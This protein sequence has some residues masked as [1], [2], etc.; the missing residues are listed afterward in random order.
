MKLK[1]IIILIGAFCIILIGLW[2]L[3]EKLESK[4]E[5]KI[6][7]ARWVT[8]E[9]YDKNI[10]AF[11]EQLT[12]NGFIEGKDIKYIT[13]NPETN[14]ESQKKIIQDF[15]DEKVDLIYS[16]TTPGTLIAKEMTSSIPIVFSIVTYPVEAKVINSLANS[17]NNLVGTRNY[18]PMERQ[19]KVFKNIYPNPKVIGFVH[20]EKE[21]NSG[22]QLEDLKKVVDSTGVKI[23]DINPLKIE[24]LSARLI[25]VKGKIDAIYSACDTLIQGGGEEIVIAFAKDNK[26]PDFT[27]NQSGIKKGSLVGNVANFTSIGALAGEKASKILKGASP[28]NLN[29]E[30]PSEDYII[31]NLKRVEDLRIS[32]K[33]EFITQAA[34]VIR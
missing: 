3:V 29:T 22:I 16:L 34:E 2:W 11:K 17:G 4:K 27:C 1:P 6:G 20:R 26:L 18:V 24:D 8:N 28:A 19:Y 25:S 30:E 15:I 12:K 7:I 31:I 14:K 10:A 33:P 9:E 21:L 13:K 5:F 32:I 23:I